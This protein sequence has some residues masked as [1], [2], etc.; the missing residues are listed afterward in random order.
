[1]QLFYLGPE[2][3]GGSLINKVRINLGPE[4]SGLILFGLIRTGI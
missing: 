2:Y 3:F 1:M 4:N